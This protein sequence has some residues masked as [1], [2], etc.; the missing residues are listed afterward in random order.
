MSKLY[1]RMVERLADKPQGATTAATTEEENG[2][3]W[4]EKM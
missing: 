1:I 4:Y 2:P 3:V